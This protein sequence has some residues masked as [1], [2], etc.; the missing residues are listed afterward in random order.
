V[1]TRAKLKRQRIKARQNEPITDAPLTRQS[2]RRETRAA[3]NLRYGGEQ[4][5][6][7]GQVRASGQAQR[8]ITDWYGNYLNQVAGAAAQTAQGYQQAAGQIGAVAD[9]S[10][11]V[12]AGNRAAQIAA[13]RAD[14]EKRG[15]TVDPTLDQTGVQA[16]A[17]RR[18]GLDEAQAATLRTG[19]TQNAYLAD[20]QRIGAGAAVQAHEQEAG[21][22][23][24]TKAKLTALQAEKGDY[25][26]QYRTQRLQAER[27]ARAT[28]AAL[29]LKQKDTLADNRRADQIAAETRR[30]NQ[31]NRWLAKNKLASAQ[32]IQDYQRSHR[33]GPFAP[34]GAKTPAERRAERRDRADRKNQHGPYAP[35]SSGPTTGP[36]R[37]QRVRAQEQ[38]AEA[39]TIVKGIKPDAQHVA[40]TVAF[41]VDKKNIPAPIAKAAVQRIV[42]GGVRHHLRRTL[43][44]TYGLKTRHYPTP[45]EVRQNAHNAFGGI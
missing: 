9:K 14:A 40:T 16:E 7:Q 8:N 5:S 27:T 6:L 10:S 37:S 4:S 15:A 31:F 20:R 44:R 35:P 30:N 1:A 19:A 17:S 34:K 12:D 11:Q 21:R 13:M 33:V 42:F 38:Y 23:R 18:V 29:G 32:E 43:H 3:V 2:L 24:A 45:A 36:S 22:K 25:K 39:K 26:V 41:L 28:D